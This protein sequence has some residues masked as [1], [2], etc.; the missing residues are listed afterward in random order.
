MSPCSKRPLFESFPS[1]SSSFTSSVALRVHW[2]D[3]VHLFICL[4][5]DFYTC[6]FCEGRVLA[7]VAQF[8]SALHWEPR[9][10]HSKCS[11]NIDWMTQKYAW[12]KW[13]LV[14]RLRHTWIYYFCLIY[15]GQP[16][17]YKLIFSSSVLS[18][19]VT[20]LSVGAI[21]WL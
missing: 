19:L 18:W 3:F 21:R 5:F 17:V 20:I 7:C 8:L 11:V 9:L 6:K 10:A 1:L 14:Y 13:V 4:F 12:L 16:A 2:N 15:S